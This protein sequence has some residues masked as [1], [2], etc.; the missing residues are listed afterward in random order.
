[1]GGIVWLASYPKSGNTWVRAF[2]HN[3]IFKTEESYDI[4]R[5]NLL[6]VGDS[7]REWYEEFLSKTCQDWSM[8]ETAAARPRV[9]SKIASLTD[10][11]I[12]VKTHNALVTHAGSPMI[13]PAL[14]AGAI[15]VI[16]NPLDIVVSMSHYFDMDLDSA[17][18]IINR[19]FEP[20]PSNEKVVY[21]MWGSW[22]ENVA[23]WT[24]KLDSSLFVLRYE[25]LLEDPMIPLSALVEFLYLCPTRRQLERAV[26]NSTF[27][28]LQ[29]QE[30]EHGFAEMPSSG[31]FF[32]K[33]VSGQWRELLNKS[34]IQAVVDA[35]YQQMSRCGYLPEHL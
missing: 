31:Q 17:I 11:L 29:A 3:L 35:H 23:T 34:Q 21:Q 14:T 27:K 10:G 19:S 26:E 18:T 16:R 15:Y 25:D 13:T 1:M 9:H 4:N 6:S 7:A 22:S 2:L 12:F 5:I 24:R 20:R 33:G 28:N 32:R 30:Q 8:G